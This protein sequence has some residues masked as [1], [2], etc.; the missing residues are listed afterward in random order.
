MEVGVT[1]TRGLPHSG[2]ELLA[3]TSLSTRSIKVSVKVS[4]AALLSVEGEKVLALAWNS[5]RRGSS[6]SCAD[7][8]TGFWPQGQSRTSYAFW[9]VRLVKPSSRS[10]TTCGSLQSSSPQGEFT[11][12]RE[13]SPSLPAIP[14]PS[15]MESRPGPAR[16]ARVGRLH[17]PRASPVPCARRPAQTLR[18]RRRRALPCPPLPAPRGSSAR[19]VQ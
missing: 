15:R 16:V 18:A 17:D 11:P 3:W 9:G 10:P 6:V 1:D 14:D 7:V 13:S 12:F 5:V 4:N 19:R 8:R 2:G